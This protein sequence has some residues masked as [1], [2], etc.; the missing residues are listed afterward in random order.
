[1]SALRYARE[2]DR[3]AFLVERVK[4]LVTAPSDRECI[5][6]LME[7]GKVEPIAAKRDRIEAS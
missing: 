2:P 6:A 4:K 1:M 5:L 3:F 7:A